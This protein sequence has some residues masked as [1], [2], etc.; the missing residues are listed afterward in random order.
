MYSIGD[1]VEH[2]KFGQGVIEKIEDGPG[3]VRLGI[4]F[5]EDIKMIDQKWMI[6]SG[7]KKVSEW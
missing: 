2:P 3:S 4:R 5:G 6:K 1:M 7:Y